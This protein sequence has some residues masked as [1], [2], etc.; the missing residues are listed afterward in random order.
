MST[1][2]FTVI[3]RPDQDAMDAA[4]TAARTFG[5]TISGNLRWF[6]AHGPSYRGVP[7][8]TAD[9]RTV[10]INVLEPGSAEEA[11]GEFLED[12]R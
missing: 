11:F 3:R 9:G 7:A 10:E 2:L 5:L 1:Q 6:G 12:G 8:V 4:A